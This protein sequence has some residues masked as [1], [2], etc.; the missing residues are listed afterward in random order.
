MGVSFKL[1]LKENSRHGDFNERTRCPL[2]V[3]AQRLTP[4]LTQELFDPSLLCRFPLGN[5]LIFFSLSLKEDRGKQ[6][7]RGLSL[8]S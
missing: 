5:L 2:E 4:V 8:F 1:T 3:T 7:I 6:N